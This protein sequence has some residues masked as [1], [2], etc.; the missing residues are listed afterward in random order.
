MLSIVIPTHNRADLLRACLASV[1]QH[2]PSG[3]E[4]I[5]VDDASKDNS[6]EIL[7][8]FTQ[9][10]SIIRL[11]RNERNLGVCETMNRGL[12]LA[13]GLEWARWAEHCRAGPPRL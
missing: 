13:Q 11:C 3:T 5:V 8:A 6:L 12:A 1:V 9:K 10:H 4:V 7:E 2:A